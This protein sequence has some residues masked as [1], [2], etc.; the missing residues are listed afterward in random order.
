VIEP[1]NEPNDGRLGDV[2]PATAAA[3]WRAVAQS[4]CAGRTCQ[5]VIAGDFSDAEHNLVSYERRYVAALAGA[6]A[7]IGHPPL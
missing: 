6:A 5:A 2:P 1:W 4:D 7:P 3:F